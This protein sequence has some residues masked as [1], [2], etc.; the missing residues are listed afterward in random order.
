[1]EM[2]LPRPRWGILFFFFAGMC[3]IHCPAHTLPISYLTLVKDKNYLHAELT[4]NPFELDFMSEIDANQD[5]VLDSAVLRDSDKLLSKRIFQ[6]IKIRADGKFL[7]AET[8]GIS[9]E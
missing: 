6:H 2:T 4:L 3:A 9:G 7:S 8:A 5:N 1:S